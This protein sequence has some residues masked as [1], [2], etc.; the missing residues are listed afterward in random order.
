MAHK[1]R[2]EELAL[3]FSLMAFGLVTEVYDECGGDSYMSAK[4]IAKRLG[5]PK[6][7]VLSV[8]RVL[9]KL[10][11]ASF[12]RGL[13]NEECEVYG[14]GY[15]L[16]PMCMEQVDNGVFMETLKHKIEAWAEL[17]VE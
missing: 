14:S 12:G 13:M 2:N 6:E 9:C 10:E 15:V 5:F 17:G 4:A 3:Y 8:M 11:Y 7:A 16:T 1:E